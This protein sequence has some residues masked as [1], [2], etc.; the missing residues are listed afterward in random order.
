MSVGKVSIYVRVST[1]QQK[2]EGISIDAQI[3]RGKQYAQQKNLEIRG[4]FRD[5]GK[6]GGTIKGR[7]GLRAAID[8]LKPGGFFVTYSL[9]RLGRSTIDNL[10]LLKEIQETKKAFFYSITEPM[11]DSSSNGQLMMTIMSAVAQHER[12]MCSDRTKEAKNYKK[13]RGE[14][15]GGTIPYGLKLGEDGKKLEEDP[16]QQKVIKRIVE[17]RKEGMAYA[18]IANR[19]EEDGVPCHEKAKKWWPESIK[20]ICLRAEEKISSV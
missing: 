11:L 3:E 2:E 20:K 6:S 10:N 4:V 12:G 7:D 13:N 5:E 19:L 15:L 14:Y 8:S 9:S 16:R 18:K 1:L 17:M